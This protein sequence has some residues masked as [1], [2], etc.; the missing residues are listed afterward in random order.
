MGG[1]N[2]SP[3]KCQGNGGWGVVVRRLGRKGK[4]REGRKGVTR[5]R[6]HPGLEPGNSNSRILSA[7][8]SS[9]PPAA[10]KTGSGEPGWSSSSTSNPNDHWRAWSW[11]VRGSPAQSAGPASWLTVPD[12]Q[13]AQHSHGW[14]PTP[15]SLPPALPSSACVPA[16]ARD[17]RPQG[18]G[19]TKAECPAG[20]GGRWIC[21]RSPWHD[22]WECVSLCIS[23][24]IFVIECNWG[25]A[26]TCVLLCGIMCLDL[27]PRG[28]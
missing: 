23:L 25:V 27:C 8:S 22:A 12:A 20:A 17:T 4:R 1:W 15:P 21:Q 19:S 6:V 18:K 2:G 13:G 3:G 24:G 26:P 11:R 5:R 14:I 7:K 28:L 16:G 10:P 9:W